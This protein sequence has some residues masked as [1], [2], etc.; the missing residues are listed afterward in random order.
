MEHPLHKQIGDALDALST[1][2]NCKIVKD[3]ACG[4][5][6]Q[7]SLFIGE[8]KNRENRICKVDAAIVIKGHLKVIVEIE[9]SGFIPTKICGKY[10]TSALSEKYIRGNENIPLSNTGVLFV[11]IVASENFSKEKKEQLRLIENLLKPLH[12]SRPFTYSL[13]LVE[14]NTKTEEVDN[15]INYIK[16]FLL[17]SL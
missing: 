7:I 5:K 15:I 12:F 14:Q 2:D 1:L 4:N 8:N 17:E 10:L 11:Q 6:Q 13:F 9:E 3:E 16:T